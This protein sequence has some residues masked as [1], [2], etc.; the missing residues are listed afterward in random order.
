MCLSKRGCLLA[1][2]CFLVLAVRCFTLPNSGTSKSV[3]FD[4]TASRSGTSES[5]NENKAARVAKV[6]VRVRDTLRSTT[7]S[8]SE[9]LPLM[10]RLERNNLREAKQLS[11]QV[12][13]EYNAP[14]ELIPHWLQV[15]FKIRV[16]P[17]AD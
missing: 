7:D 15:L 13:T 8:E 9:K 12:H 17:Q 14:R 4:L 2:P 16:P 6:R 3:S 5:S 11:L 1:K 10:E